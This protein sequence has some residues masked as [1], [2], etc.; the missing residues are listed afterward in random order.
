MTNAFI[1]R[2]KNELKISGMGKSVL[3]RRIILLLL[4]AVLCS[5]VMSAGIYMVVARRQYVNIR[6]KELAPI[7]RAVS[8][9]MTESQ[10]NGSFG[11]G[12]LVLLDR[13]NRD[14]GATLHVF[15]A[16]GESVMNSVTLGSGRRPGNSDELSE[17]DAQVMLTADMK[18]V[19]GGTEVSQIR[20]SADETYLVV[21]VPITSNGA[22][23]G[24]VFFTKPTSEL[25]E[26]FGGL[27]ITLIISTL[28]AFL[29]MLIPGYLAARHL[30]IPIR[31]MR[32]VAHAMSEGNFD[33]RADSGQKGE[34]GELAR[35][36]NQ[37]ARESARLEQTRRD[38]VANVSHELR[39]PI[40][41]IRAMGETLRDGMAKT[42]E[43]RY[44]FYNNIV[45]ESMRL[46]RLVDDLL[47]LSR[48]QAG[49]EAMQKRAFDLREILGNISDGYSHIAAANGVYFSLE[50]DMSEPVHVFSNPDRVEQVLVILTDN[51]LKHTTSGGCVS[52]SLERRNGKATIMVANTG[53]EI[54]AE[55]LPH[56]FERFYKVDKSHSGGGTGLG[57]SIAKEIVK[58]LAEEIHVMSENGETRFAFTVSGQ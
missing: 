42:D 54:P 40:A 55:D 9:M 7:A 18:T 41:S 52:I 17:E 16:N 36:M 33:V 6:A 13:N 24:A 10:Q 30:V 57:L 53:E 35:S 51:A 56:I 20:T 28:A 5:G 15:N 23:I 44:L 26:T 39:T 1:S 4:A 45:R 27:N 38:Y 34:I 29:V 58:G 50:A 49:R 31:Q 12:S 21:G 32:E 19:L 3:L 43:K 25:S 37:F 47:E 22:V 11:F 48:L 8:D 2:V 14:F 46:S